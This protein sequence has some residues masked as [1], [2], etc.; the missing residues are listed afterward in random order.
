M[1]SLRICLAATFLITTWVLSPAQVAPSI[2]AHPL[3]TTAVAGETV[4]LSVSATGTGPLSYQWLRDS[5]PIDGATTAQLSIPAAATTDSGPYSVTVSNSFGSATSNTA[6]LTVLTQFDAWRIE[7]FSDEELLDP[8]RSGPLAIYGSDG[9]TNLLKYALGIPPGSPAHQHR[10]PRMEADEND[11][12]FIF[13]ANPS[14][15]DITVA[16]EFSTD[17]SS[18]SWTLL[19]T[20]PQKRA[21]SEGLEIWEGRLPRA[22]APNRVFFRL[23]VTRSF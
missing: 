5:Q 16:V 18:G 9:I 14:A 15:S 7:H 23:R 20:A 21:L 3:D 4:F 10:L 6:T 22:L 11:W 2:T 19:P 13:S 8:D 17:L 12:V 1:T